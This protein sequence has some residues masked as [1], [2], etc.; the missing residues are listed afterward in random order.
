MPYL[1]RQDIEIIA[2]RVVSAYKR[3]PSHNGREV[4]MVQPNL[5][6]CSLLG[7]SVDHHTLSRSGAILGLTSCGPVSVPIFDDPTVPKYYDLDGRTLLIDSGLLAEGSNKGRYNFTLV[8][9]ACH[10]IYRMLFPR[11][12]MVSI[13]RRK[14][15]YCTTHAS[16]GAGDW[17]EWRTNTLA[18]AILMPADMVLSNMDAFGLGNS[19]KMRNKGFA[20]T[21]YRK[22]EQMADYMGVSKQALAVRL[23]RLSLLNFDYLED[24]Y[25]LVDIYP[26]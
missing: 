22:F 18:S 12:Y 4:N 10:Q 17:E 23:K 13:V 20:P 1:S 2:Q 9:E 16:F 21:E 11:A 14:V 15:H 19:L 5:L 25:A 24:P 6:V 7:L 3:L 26:D 8:H